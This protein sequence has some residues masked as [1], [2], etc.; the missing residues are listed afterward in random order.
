ME[1]ATKKLLEDSED[2]DRIPG[3][4]IAA[5]LI[6]TE[7]AAVLGVLSRKVLGQYE[8]VLPTGGA[9]DVVAYVGP[10]ILQIERA[11]QF[12]PAEFRFWVALHE[13]TH[14][15]QFQ[16]IPWLRDYF[17]SLVSE[18]VESSQPEP[19]RWDRVMDELA[20]RWQAKI[21]L[22]DER[23]VFGLFATPEQRGIIDRIQALMS[24]LEGHGH[25]VMDR[26]G[27]DHLKS[28]DRMSR[29]LK[30]RRQDKRTRAFF[31]ITGLEMKLRQYE[32]GEKFIAGVERLAGWEA[33][34]LAFRGASSL[35]TLDEIGAPDR[36]LARVD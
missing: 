6:E 15:A 34:R 32:A 9:A 3:A 20:S 5:K 23:G 21:P 7:T 16:G 33:V 35:P 24:F 28:Q 26:L 18:M 36:W 22:I 4:L 11:N 2:G 1:P 14:R 12:N 31:R 8:L 27:A 25:V 19:D 13:M 10:N 30:A 17:M 29:V